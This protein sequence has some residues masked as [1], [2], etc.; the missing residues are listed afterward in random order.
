M[1]ATELNK[2]F[3]LNQTVNFQKISDGLVKLVVNN[4]FSTAEIHLQGA[5]LTSYC[6]NGQEDIFW[7]SP[8]A[9][10][11]LNKAIR[12]GVPICWPWFG[13][14]PKDCSLPQHGFARTSEFSVESIEESESGQ[15]MVKLVL[16]SNQ[17][18]L[19]VWP[20]QFKLVVQFI[21]GKTIEI[22]V[23]THNDANQEFFLME[24]IHSYFAIENI[25]HTRLQGLNGLVFFDQLIQREEINRDDLVS[26]SSEVDAIYEC[27]PH[28]L[29]LVQ[30]NKP[31]LGI[32][33]KHANSIVVWNPWVDKAASMSDFPDDGY[34]NMLCIESSNTRSKVIVPASHSHTLTQIITP[35][36][37]NE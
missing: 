1:K 26:V 18:T 7:L 12:G 19:Q 23:I 2:Q 32:T 3:E 9:N 6:L 5:H 31:A 16:S 17:K 11:Q 27:P 30:K 20:Y 13:K 34:Q 36:V 14:H 25:E 33:S 37:S 10:Y 15:T 28:Q 8:I 29:I 35:S 4:Q 22:S 24:A 21:I